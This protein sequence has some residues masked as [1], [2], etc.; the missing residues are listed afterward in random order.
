[1]Y[2]FL[3]SNINLINKIVFVPSEPLLSPHIVTMAITKID[4]LK[5]RFILIDHFACKDT[6][7]FFNPQKKMVYVSSYIGHKTHDKP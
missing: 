5:N 4:T 7:I 2:Y 3:L 6:P 1:M